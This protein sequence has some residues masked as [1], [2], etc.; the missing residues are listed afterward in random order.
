[1]GPPRPVPAPLAPFARRL[2]GVNVVA[3]W[4]LATVSDD[5]SAPLPDALVVQA[6]TG[7]VTLS[8]GRSGLTC[9]GA[10]RRD[11]IRLGTEP[12]LLVGRSDRAEEWLDLVPPADRSDVPALPLFVGSLTGWFGVGPRVE[13]FA[14]VLAGDDRELAITTA[15]GGELRCATRR[16]ARERAGLLADELR[17]ELV[18]QEARL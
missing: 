1:M 10:E 17:L 2:L 7:F 18:G 4:R 11:E 13:A 3:L 14:L 12:D 15:D 9:R 16:E 6:N 8:H 5:G